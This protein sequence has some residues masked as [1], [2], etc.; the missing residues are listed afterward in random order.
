MLS[1]EEREKKALQEEGQ[2]PTH[3]QAFKTK[4]QQGCGP[5]RGVRVGPWVG[6][7]GPG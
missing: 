3:A 2:N 5:V 7:G 4:A 1:E 6:G